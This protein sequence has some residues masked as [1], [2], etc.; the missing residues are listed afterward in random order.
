MRTLPALVSIGLQALLALWSESSQGTHD[1]EAYSGNLLYQIQNPFAYIPRI[2]FEN[3]LDSGEGPKDSS[4]YR[5]RIRPIIPTQVS[6]DFNLLT[7][8]TLA[9]RYQSSLYSGG[10]NQFGYGDTDLEFYFSPRKSLAHDSLLIGFGPSVHLPTATQPNLGYQQ[11]GAG[12]SGAVI[13]QPGTIYALRGWTLAFNINQTFG[14]APS[15]GAQTKSLLFLLPSA[16]YTTES[17]ITLGVDIEP[18]L[19]WTN[20]KWTA[21]VNLWTSHLVEPLGQPTIITLDGRY[22][23]ERTP[24]DPKWGVQVNFNFLFPN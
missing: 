11:W 13:W 20:G 2:E 14:F 5:F 22:Y 15:H 8:A 6:E 24:Y 10:P 3:H 17:E 4:T 16:T 21:P 1:L 7:R 23:F 18:Y 12:A 19:N 9:L